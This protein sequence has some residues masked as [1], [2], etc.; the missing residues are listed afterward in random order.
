MLHENKHINFFLRLGYF[1]LIVL[2]VSFL[3]RYGLRI[4]WPFLTALL[5]S[6]II[7]RPVEFISRKTRLPRGPLAACFILVLLALAATLIYL[8]A[9]FLFYRSMALLDALPRLWEKAQSDLSLFEHSMDSLLREAFPFLR[10]MPFLSIESLL[11]SSASSIDVMGVF[12]TVSS[13]AFSI[14]SLLFTTVFI[15]LGTYFFTVQREEIHEF[16]ARLISPAAFEA[17][18]RLREFLYTSVFRWC[19]AQL[20]LICITCGELIC[21]FLL[22]R[23]ENALPLAMLIALIDALP[24]LGVGTV[25]IPWSIFCLLTGAFRKALGLMLTYLVVLCV[26]NSIEPRVVGQKIGLNPF[27]T[28]LSMY[29]GYRLGGFFGL[30]FVPIAVLSILHLQELGYLNLWQD[31]S[32]SAG[33][34]KGANDPHEL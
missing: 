33:L 21:A 12:S 23:Q 25:L 31:Q 4:A 10:D 6:A 34:S 30:A 22:L 8:L 13:A 15:F 16:L 20:L 5:F 19:K 9:S 28:L 3:A 11:F 29:I 17:A 1:L 7:R 2:S 27:V 24:I 18:V 26:R 32:P 14:P